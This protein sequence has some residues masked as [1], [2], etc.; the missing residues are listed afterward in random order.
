MIDTAT[1]RGKIVAAAMRLAP[2]KGWQALSLADI[3]AEAG[4]S[5]NDLRA[6]FQTKA[7]ILAAFT[8]MIDEEVLAKQ[9]AAGEAST[10]RDR[11]FDVIMSRFDALAPYKEAI[12]TI[13]DDLR[14]SPGAAL[15]QL[16]PVLYSQYWMLA[17][18]GIPAEGMRGLV[19]VKAMTALYGRVF[20]IWLEDDDPGMARTMA[21]LD[22]RFRQ[23]E[24]V[25]RRIDGLC[26]AGDR[27]LS[28]LTGRSPRG[29]AGPAPEAPKTDT[30]GG[31]PAGEPGFSA[32]G[33]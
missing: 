1:N 3:A 33:A 20:A 8:R 21:A 23:A 32:P 13:A 26:E 14:F 28:A 6:E 24:A 7:Q 18:A 30:S 19:R 5:L 15:A 25:K 22:R 27:I 29:Q 2:I 11:L 12:R 17:A 4:V 31:N 9:H 10:P 16:G